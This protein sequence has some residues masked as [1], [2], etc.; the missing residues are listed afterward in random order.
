M[1]TW[2]GTGTTLAATWDGTAT[3]SS[4]VPDGTY[5]WTIDATDGWQNGPTTRIGSVSVDTVAGPL[6]SVTPVDDPGAWFSPNGDGSRDTTSWLATTTESGSVGARI[7]DGTGAT[8][9]YLSVVAGVGPVGLTWDGTDASGQLVP[10]GRYEVRLY[11]RDAAG[12][13]GPTTVRSINV[14]TTL[15]WVT[16]SKSL[17]YPQDGDALGPT[18]TV[19]FRLARPAAVTVTIRNAAGATVRTLIDG[20]TRAAGSWTTPFDGR[21]D[22][23]AFL[24]TGLYRAVVTAADGAFASTQSVVFQM[25]AFVVVASDA[26][27]ARGQR[28]TVSATSAEVLSS[29]PRLIVSQ[30]GWAA[31][32]VAMT[33]ISTYRYRATITLKTG[34]S[35]VVAFTVRGYDHYLQRQ[36]TSKSYPLH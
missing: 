15:G 26:T 7:V 31:W 35:G 23:G 10:D 32:S 25:D 30:P 5:M 14:A 36:Q 6:A 34:R 28:L 18:T 4:T 11:A 24:P 19:G 2:T 17:F 16:S 22:G 29:P 33:K 21:G 13:Q 12:N 9:R 1:R 27:P 20:E 3:D 8:V